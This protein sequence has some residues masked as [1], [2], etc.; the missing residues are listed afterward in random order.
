MRFELHRPTET[1]V[2]AGVAGAITVSGIAILLSGFGPEGDGMLAA[3]GHALASTLEQLRF[4]HAFA[5][6]EVLQAATEAV[7]AGADDAF[8]R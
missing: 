7:R 5:Y 4:A 2:G 6:G 8:A 1:A 3:P